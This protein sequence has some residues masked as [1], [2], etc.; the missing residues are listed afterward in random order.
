M[1]SL[2]NSELYKCQDSGSRKVDLKLSHLD[3]SPE[4]TLIHFQGQ[5]LDIYELDYN[6]LQQ[7]IQRTPKTS[8]AVDIGEF[9]LVEDANSAHWYRGRTQGH[10]DGIFDVFLID[11]GNILS[12]DI[13]HI[14]SCS[15]DFLM[16]PPK[17][18][19]G[20]LANML[21]VHSTSDCGVGEYLSNLVGKTTTGY[22][23]AFLPHGVLL[24]EVPYVNDELV[25]HGFGK[26]IDRDTFLLLVELV[27]EVPLKQNTDKLSRQEHCYKLSAL[28]VYEEILSFCGPRMTCGS[29]AKVR[30]T[31]A[32]NPGL[33][34]CQVANNE[35]DLRNVSKRLAAVC[36]YGKKDNH[37]KNQQ[38]LG[39]LCAVKSKNGK[40]YRGFVKLLPV[41]SQV[42][43]LFIDYGFSECVKLADVHKLPSDLYF[44]PIM[45]FPCSLSALKAKDEEVKGQQL[46]FLKAGLLGKML[47][48]EID[49]FDE[50]HHLYSVWVVGTV[51]DV[52]ETGPSQQLPPIKAQS[53]ITPEAEAPKTGPLSYKTI[54]GR[55]L[56]K[57]LDKEELQLHSVFEGYFEH[58]LNPHNFWIRTQKR[59]DE[60]QEMMNKMSEH[61]CQVALED[62]ILLNPKPGTLCCALYEADNN[63]YRAVVTDELQHGAEV[64]FID[65]GNVEKVPHTF[66]K[67]I[68]E[69]FAAIPAFGI[70]C[71][72]VNLLPLDD[73]WTCLNSDFFREAISNKALLVHL[74]HISQHRCVVDLYEMVSDNS[75]SI[76]ELLVSSKQAY[77]WNNIPI[78]PV[79]KT[80][81]QTQQNFTKK[82]VEQG[83]VR[84]VP[85]S[86]NHDLPKS[87]VYSSFDLASNNEIQ[88]YVTHVSSELNVYCQLERN[89]EILKE[90][91]VKI[92]EERKKV[93]HVGM[94]N[95]PIKVCLAKYYDG[96]WYRVL[97]NPSPSPLHFSVFFVDYGN[98][99]ISEKSQVVSIPRDCDHLLSTP[100]QALK[101]NL[102]GV[103]NKEF[104]IEVKTWLDGSVLNKQLRAIIVQKCDDDSF[105]VELFDGI[106]NI[107]NKVNELIDS[108]SSK[109]KIEF[110]FIKNK[111]NRDHKERGCSLDK[112]NNLPKMRG[113]YFPTF[114]GQRGSH[115]RAGPQRRK[116]YVKVTANKHTKTAQLREQRCITAK[117]TSMKSNFSR[118]P[119]NELK[120]RQQQT[121][122]QN[123]KTEKLSADVSPQLPRLPKRKEKAGSSMMCFVTHVN[124]VND[125][126]LQLSYD[127]PAILKLVDEINSNLLSLKA[128]LSV[129]ISDL[130]LAQYDEDAAVYRAV[131]RAHEGNCCFK[132]DFLDYGNSAVV[133]KNVIY[134]FP[135]EFLS[136]PPFSIRCSLRDSSLYN[137]DTS[138]SD[139]VMEK[140]LRVNFVR[141]T[142]TYWEVDIE[143]LNQ[144]ETP[145]PAFESDSESWKERD[146]PTAPLFDDQDEVN[147][148]DFTE[149]E[150]TESQ[151]KDLILTAS[152]TLTLKH[153]AKY[154]AK[155]KSKSR[156]I[157]KKTSVS[158]K[159]KS[160]TLITQAKQV[161]DAVVLSV[162][163]HGHFYVRP[164]KINS[165]LAALECSIAENVHQC[166]VV[167]QEDIKPGFKCLVQIHKDAQWK[168]A[169]V[170]QV[171]EGNYHLFLVDEGLTLQITSHT[172]LKRHFID[173]TTIPNLAVLCK[174]ISA[175]GGDTLK[176]MIGQ[177]V[178]L[179]FV[180]Y[181]KSNHFWVVQQIIPLPYETRH[182]SSEELCPDTSTP[183]TIA[184]APVSLDK[185]YSGF[186]TA[187]T[188][189]SDFWV[190]L[191]DSLPLMNQVA[192]ML[193]DL[194]EGLPLLP[195]HSLAPGASCLFQSDL[196]N[197]K[198]CIAEIVQVDTSVV[199]N[200]VD[201]G[202]SVRVPYEDCA[203]LRTLPEE[204]M[205]LPKRVYP[206][207]LR[208]VRPVGEDRQWSQEGSV[209]FQKCLD[210]SFQV[211]F[212]EGLSN[213][214]WTVDIVMDGV[215]VAKRLVDAGH[216]KYTDALLGLR[217]QGQSPSP[218]YRPDTEEGNRLEASSQDSA[219]GSGDIKKKLASKSL[220]TGQ[221]VLQ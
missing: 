23:E 87:F 152:K 98:T 153:K 124:S 1:H 188:T 164:S 210:H 214:R 194:S 179:V 11:Y 95:V 122:M 167:V 147:S 187:V 132:V 38:N 21:V 159:K 140:P 204:L 121:P 216:A 166:E 168:R 205:N 170:Q 101:F 119:Q 58:A 196:N 154:F 77:Y 66:I 189:P 94:E 111:E 30:V 16:L 79:V 151:T 44:T 81:N 219:E 206:C 218:V 104:F 129:R 207:C 114:H 6:I 4:A 155:I 106:L 88:V 31:A 116:D 61:F 96:K 35:T 192:L 105:D 56:V 74:V 186:A 57:T 149:K 3:W 185:E 48:V 82:L 172:P 113:S 117:T 54:K 2:L 102:V 90:L 177:D 133:E 110:R 211:V 213:S 53:C 45:A 131:V 92:S 19:C 63:F 80:N 46:G 18:V 158:I 138:F 91:E 109:P 190:V 195:K 39:L 141:N 130:V 118:K 161:E 28:Q 162:L 156:R 142:G 40:W 10:K 143:V 145:E 47:E 201:Y 22:V 127:E 208:A 200:L 191:E 203:S 69:T 182:Q 123:Y 70:C 59:N 41:K 84:E 215:H 103:S 112:G 184:F 174:T 202:L 73:V 128:A 7:A 125:F 163:S 24:L 175:N 36:E 139:A 220:A 181:A 20:F 49:S 99:G 97:V 178:Q 86:R 183:Q 76:S 12:V 75:L 144:V 78:K 37:Q 8:A 67:K 65:F 26:H 135:P 197:N 32:V 33:F 217:F 115:V 93:K 83:L 68:P 42:R 51:Q 17:I 169:V 25:R 134:I 212:R 150:P 136:Q 29:R 60:F 160:E 52:T 137:S 71:T 209:H 157:P 55:E 108:L 107:N 27:I 15:N 180:T 89:M 64:L 176:T 173:G 5:Y 13:A 146:A 43:V 221:C 199:L 120:A 85:D 193:E 62:D 126:F 148:C 165:L 9:C 34:Y 50:E 100:M 171:S 198:W 72:L 14:S